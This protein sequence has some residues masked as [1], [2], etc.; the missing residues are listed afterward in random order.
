MLERRTHTEITEA[1]HQFIRDLLPEMTIEE[2]DNLNAV[3]PMEQV[4]LIAPPATGLIMA[5]V[6]DCFD[7]DF[8][9]GEVLVTRA[10]ISF[11]DHRAQATLIGNLP[12]HALA[13]ATLSVL[14]TAGRVDLLEKAAE[15]CLPASRRI[16]RKR[17]MRTRLVSAT[18]VRF[19]SM[20]G[21]R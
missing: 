11:G 17:D 13:A 3:L 1:S 16:A 10:E 21:G 20:A 4:E 2:V 12:K 9:L 6:R 19:E 15:A 8:Y 18:R 7:T 5:R 14:E